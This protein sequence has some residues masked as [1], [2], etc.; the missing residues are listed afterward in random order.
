MVNISEKP[1][2]H[3]VARAR[4][5]IYIQKETLR[6][7][8]EG[9]I[10]KGEVFPASQLAG[11][12]A[13]K[14]TA[15]ILPLCHQINLDHVSVSFQL[16]ADGIVCECLSETTYGTGVEMEALLGVSV[17]LLNIWDMVKQYEKEEG[18]YPQTRIGD[19]RVIEKRK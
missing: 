15:H 18:K 12:G 17:A 8:Q 13:A 11:I 9:A 19:I 4:G 1:H 14:N 7:I 6:L 16:E 2:T 3:R 10:E 5:K